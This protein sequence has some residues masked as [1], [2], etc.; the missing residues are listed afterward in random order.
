MTCVKRDGIFKHEFVANLLPSPL[1]KKKFENRIIVEVM[2]KN[3]VSCFFDSR[4]ILICHML[5]RWTELMSGRINK[6]VKHQ[7]W[8]EAKIAELPITI[9][10]RFRPPQIVD[11]PLNLAGLLTHCG[12]L[13]F[14]KISKSDA[15]RCQILRL[16]CTKFDFC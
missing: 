14:R 9:M 6:S 4:C 1:V 7:P 16:K 13:I 15:S 2:D 11:R 8:V 3:L 5:Q 12:Q 10:W